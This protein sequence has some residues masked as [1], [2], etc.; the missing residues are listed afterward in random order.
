[1]YARH[2][3]AIHQCPLTTRAAGVNAS[4]I[5][6]SQLFPAGHQIGWAGPVAEMISRTYDARPRQSPTESSRNGGL[7][8][9]P[10]RL[11]DRAELGVVGIGP[12]H[13]AGESLQAPVSFS[14]LS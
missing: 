9:R 2:G 8:V 3:N 10:G 5:V 7:G 11:D 13:R 4:R 1:M 14:P 12:A 6:G